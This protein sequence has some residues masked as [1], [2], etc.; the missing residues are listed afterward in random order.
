M[1]KS[2]EV[3]QEDDEETYEDAEEEYEGKILKTS[4]HDKNLALFQKIADS[5]S[6]VQPPSKAQ[7]QNSEKKIN[8][9][10]SKNSSLSDSSG[11]R[12]S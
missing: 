3:S 5:F 8:S 2:I 11:L 7:D 1:N 12:S 9:I 10:K 6:R 4:F